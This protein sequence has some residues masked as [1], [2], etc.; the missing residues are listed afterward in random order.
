VYHWFF[1]RA[2]ANTTYRILGG[3]PGLGQISSGDSNAAETPPGSFGQAYSWTGSSGN[4]IIVAA[5]APPASG[6]AVAS[7]QV[8]NTKR[9][10]DD[11]RLGCL[12]RRTQDRLQGNADL[13]LI[14]PALSPS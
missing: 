14:Q 6:A 11:P 5:L 4:S 8:R 3:A 9:W 7:P 12:D 2:G 1:R 13:V 10:H